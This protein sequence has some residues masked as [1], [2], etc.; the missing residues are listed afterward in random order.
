MHFAVDTSHVGF[1]ARTQSLADSIFDLHSCG[2]DLRGCGVELRVQTG[3][4]LTPVGPLRLKDR[5]APKIRFPSGSLPSI[6]APGAHCQR[7]GA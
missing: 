1:G 3:E 7:A 5:S 6:S 4:F 2:L